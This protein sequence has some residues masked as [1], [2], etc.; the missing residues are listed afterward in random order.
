MAIDDETKRELDAIRSEFRDGLDDLKRAGT[1]R[2]REHAR[3]EIAGA[4]EDLEDVLR[5]EGYRLSR[6]ELDAMIDARDEERFTARLDAALEARAAAEA[7]EG[8]EDGD[9]DG[10]DPKKKKPPAGRK[11]TPAKKPA[12]SADDGETEEEWT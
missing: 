3:G 12:G 8:E 7:E 6:R 10:D 1:T 5:R 2:E 9:G 11:R 4:R